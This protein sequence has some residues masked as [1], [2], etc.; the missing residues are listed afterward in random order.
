MKMDDFVDRWYYVSPAGAGGTVALLRS[1]EKRATH[2]LV[3]KE[4]IHQLVEFW[5]RCNTVAPS[6]FIPVEQREFLPE[7]ECYFDKE[8][9]DS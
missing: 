7:M 6:N 2:A 8:S 1:D 4:T 3:K 9:N 5:I